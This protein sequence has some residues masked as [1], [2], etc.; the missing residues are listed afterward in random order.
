MAMTVGELVDYLVDQPRDR[1]VV[2]AKDA[3]G[4]GYSPLSAAEEA[5][6]VPESTWSGE[7]YPTPEQIATEKDPADW[8]DGSG[9]EGAVRVVLLGPVN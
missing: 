8:F 3:E 5:I 1:S 9:E 7:I 2:L 6:Y 4:N